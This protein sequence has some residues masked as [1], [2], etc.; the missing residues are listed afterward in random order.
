MSALTFSNFTAVSVSFLAYF[1]LSNDYF[2][3][4]IWLANPA[5]CIARINHVPEPSPVNIRPVRFAP[6]AAGAR[7]TTRTSA[8]GSP[9]PGTGFPQYV[10][11]ANS[12]LP[13]AA[14]RSQYRRSRGHAVHAT[15][16]R[17]TA[18][19]PSRPITAR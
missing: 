10:H 19:S 9:K 13:A 14:T 3:S 1:F 7:P 15:T 11:P 2:I 5:R 8:R 18:A 17:D 16:S 4:Y 12:G 6:C